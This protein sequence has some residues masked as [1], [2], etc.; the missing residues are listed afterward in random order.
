MY[1]AFSIADVP[2]DTLIPAGWYPAR[3]VRSDLRDLKSGD[4]QRLVLTYALQ[5]GPFAERR[6]DASFN[7]DHPNP[8]AVEIS[9]KE[10]A[11]VLRACGVGAIQDT[12]ELHDR[13][14]Q[15]RVSV[16]TYNDRDQNRITD[17]RPLSPV[18]VPS[19]ATSA[20]A[21]NPAQAA[22]QAASQAFQAPTP[23]AAP[24][25][26]RPARPAP[27]PPAAPFPT[28][29]AASTL[30]PASPPDGQSAPQNG[31]P[32]NDDIPW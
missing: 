23:P 1:F 17:W 13:V 28:P 12:L 24:P 19:A 30:T 3:I 2:D 11:K 16:N 27:L 32:F 14:H 9:Q 15:V 25:A 8:Q 22:R 29:T 5:G 4:G 7:V 20:P 31:I 18:A 6:V 10:L 21:P 26:P